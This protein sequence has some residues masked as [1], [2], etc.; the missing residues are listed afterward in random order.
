MAFVNGQIT[1]PKSVADDGDLHRYSA[2]INGTKIRFLLYRKPNGDVATVYDA[3]TICGSV[4]F[5][6]S[7][8]GIICKNCAAPINA[9]SVGQ[10]GG[11]NPIPLKAKVVGDSLVITASD[12][13]EQAAQFA[14]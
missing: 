13:G 14:K 10:P 3:C 11:C 2:D 9:Q 8:N 6:K 4:G 5:Y 7:A 1:L 12:L